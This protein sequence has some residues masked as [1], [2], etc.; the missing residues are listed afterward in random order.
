MKARYVVAPEAARD[1]V[2]IWDYVA[3]HTSRAAA[4]QV[5]SVILQKLTFL[6]QNPGVGHARKD[7]TEAD[8]KFFAV[9]SYLICTGLTRPRCRSWQFCM[10]VAIWELK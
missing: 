8:V 6:S 5:E 2:Q 3:R 10:V 9:Y 4:D 1:L 7:L